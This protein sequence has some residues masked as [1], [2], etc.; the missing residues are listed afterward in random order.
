MCCDKHNLEDVFTPPSLS[1]QWRTEYQ[2]MIAIAATPK[3]SLAQIHV[4]AM[5]R[6]RRRLPLAAACE[7]DR[8]EA[9]KTV[10]PLPDR[11]LLTSGRRPTWQAQ[12]L[13]R[14]I[15]LYSVA[16]FNNYRGDALQAAVVMQGLYLPL[17]CHPD[18]CSTCSPLA[19]GYTRGH[20]NALLAME[21]ADGPAAA[22]VLL[23]AV[24][25]SYRPLDV[26]YA[27]PADG[28]LPRR[29]LAPGLMAGSWLLTVDNRACRG[30]GR[31]CGGVLLGHCHLRGGRPPCAAAPGRS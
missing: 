13:R 26:P 23:P 29:P 31:P 3:Q 24:D 1:W 5:V 27:L 22:G 8:C 12:L 20:F 9:N 14:P 7:N 25:A 6:D 17:L 30:P 21:P 28:G 10:I 15:V 11:R 2:Q 19:L 16:N 4:F 18:D